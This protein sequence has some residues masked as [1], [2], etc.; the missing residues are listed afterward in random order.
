ML[1]KAIV[2][3]NLVNT[4]IVRTLVNTRKHKAWHRVSNVHV[5]Y[6]NFYRMGSE[7]C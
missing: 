7:G 4:Y 6:C 5:T 3:I 2:K 1:F